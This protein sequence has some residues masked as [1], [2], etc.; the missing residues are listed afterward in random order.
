[1][2]YLSIEM[3]PKISS[4]KSDPKTN[5][6]TILQQCSIVSDNLSEEFKKISSS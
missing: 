2:K 1:M 3:Y 4:D 5:L 6:S